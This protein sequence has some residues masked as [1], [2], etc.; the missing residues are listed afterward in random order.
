MLG[1]AAAS[2]R[3][4]GTDATVSLTA[5]GT[6]QAPDQLQL[7][8]AQPGRLVAVDVHAGEVVPVGTLLARLDPAPA[9]A[10]IQTAAANLAAARAQLLQLRQGLAPAERAQLRVGLRQ[11]QQALD[12]ARRSLLDARASAAQDAT[13]LHTALDQANAQLSADQSALSRDQGALTADQSAV[14]TTTA[15]V[16]SNRSQL[17]ADQAALVKAQKQQ[18]DD[19]ANSAPAMTLA[20]DANAILSDQAAVDA[21]Q[22]RL[23]DDTSAVGDA[24]NAVSSDQTRVGADQNAIASDQNAVTN[25]TNAAA[26]GA[27]SERQSVDAAQAAVDSSALGLSA[28]RAANA[29]HAE[30]PRVGTLAATRAAVRVAE[31]ALATAEQ[32]LAETRLVAPIAGTIA[33]VGAVPG[34]LV[35]GG[36]GSDPL[37]TLVDLDYLTVTASFDGAEAALLS[38]GQAASVTVPELAGR[39]LAGRIVA[40]DPLPDPPMDTGNSSSGAASG[41]SGSP[42]ANGAGTSTYSATISLTDPP[43]RLWPGM[44]TSVAVTVATTVR[45]G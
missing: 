35:S 27:A 37:I 6:V 16:A 15:Q 43:P 28:T 2:G 30:P 38:P 22:A 40:V 4:A 8:F 12:A 44:E 20:D 21:D 26:S 42:P 45:D 31:S 19:N 25:A 3:S 17:A 34:Q 10:G 5:S 11:S 39:E 9:L 36:G 7:A 14:A 29:V 24:R 32:A 41:T 18:T 13:G 33:T 1:L 23:A